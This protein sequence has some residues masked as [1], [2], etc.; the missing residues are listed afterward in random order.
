M[1][2][3]GLI[4]V[5]GLALIAAPG[6]ALAAG[7]FHGG[8]GGGFHGGGFHGGGFHGGG[9]YVAPAPVHA[10]PGWGYRGVAPAYGRGVAPV[11]RGAPV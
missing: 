2:R 10:A 11:Y 9:H 7:G 3:L 6:A 1:K 4:S 5:L 8:G